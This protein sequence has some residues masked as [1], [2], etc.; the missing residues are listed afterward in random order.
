MNLLTV[1]GLDVPGSTVRGCD[2]QAI[3][4]AVVAAIPNACPARFV[5]QGVEDLC[6]QYAN[7]D[8]DA[9]SVPGPRRPVHLE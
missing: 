4:G 3:G 5:H 1:C 6:I 9:A 2:G 7:V 8:H